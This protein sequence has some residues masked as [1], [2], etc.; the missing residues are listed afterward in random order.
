MM[1]KKENTNNELYLVDGSKGNYRSEIIY[2]TIS[3]YNI[4]IQSINSGDSVWQEI[5]L[6]YEKRWIV[7][8]GQR[9]ECKLFD[10][11]KILQKSF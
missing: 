6:D 5:G 3:E 1:N 8:D 7:K 11:R 9:F 10:E 2:I 4:M